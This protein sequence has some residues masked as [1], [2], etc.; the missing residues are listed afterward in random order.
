M[1]DKTPFGV[2]LIRYDFICLILFN[3][4]R[5]LSHP[6]KYNNLLIIRLILYN[7]STSSF[8]FR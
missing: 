5:F 8:F 6:K 7:D 1:N 4:I 3:F 2:I